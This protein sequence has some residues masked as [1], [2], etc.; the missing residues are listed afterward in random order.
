M[1]RLLCIAFCLI[2]VNFCLNA[3][4]LIRNGSF[5]QGLAHWT[6]KGNGSVDP[7]QGAF[8]K[9]SLKISLAKPVWQ[10]VFQTVDVEPST[11]YVLEYYVKCEKVL[12][13]KGAKFSGAGSWISMKKYFPH[14]GSA[15]PWKLDSADG[16]WRKVSYKF[17]TGKEDKKIAVQ[18]QLSNA[19]GTVWIDQVSLKKCVTSP[20][21]KY[22]IAFELN[23][24]KFLQTTPFTIAENLTGTLQ[25]HMR[26]SLKVR[27]SDPACM[28]FDVPSFIRVTGG[29]PYLSMESGT[30]EN[31]RR[32]LPTY[33]VEDLGMVKRSGKSFHRYRLI[34]DKY[35]KR[36]ISASWYSQFIFFKAEKGSAGKSGEFYCYISAG[37]ER[38]AEQKGFFKVVPPLK[39]AEKPTK[40]FALLFGKLP[41]LGAQN[42][43]G[44]EVNRA[45]W[46]SLAQKRYSWIRACD[47]PLKGFQPIV[48]VGGGFWSVID[49]VQGDLNALKKSLPRNITDKGTLRH[50]LAVWSKVDDKSGRVERLY[51]T[52]AKEVKRLYPEVKDVVWDFEPHPYGFDKGGRERF[53]RYMKL[54]EV[55]SI[56]QINSKYRTEWF[57][58]MVKLHAEYANNCMRIFKEAAPGVNFWFCS[59]NLYATGNHISSWC[60][61]DVRLSDDVAD[62][63]MHMPY[64]AGKRFFDDVR[65]NIENLKKPFFPLIDPSEA[66][67]SFYK[68]Y[69]PA[70]VKQNILAVA[71]RGGK[72][73]GFW[74]HDAFTAEYFQAIAEGFGMV[75]EAEEFYAKGKRAEKEFRVTPVNVMV[76]TVKAQNGKSVKL[77]FPD[78]PSVLRTVVH[79]YK[80]EVLFTLFNYHEKESMILELKGRGKTLYVNVPANGVRVVRLS[81]KQDPAVLKALKDFKAKSSSARLQ[82]MKKGSASLL[83]S[84][85]ESGSPCFRMQNGRI[86]AAVDV[87]KDG[88][89]ISLRSGSGSELLSGGF[90]GWLMFYDPQQQEV[91]SSI[92]SM[93]IRN[94]VPELTLKGV[95]GPYAGANPVPNPLLDMEI[96]RKY[97][98]KD[99]KLHMEFTFKNPTKKAMK[100]GFRLNNYPFPGK[101]FGAERVDCTLLSGGKRVK[102]S[103]GKNTFAYKGAVTP[104]TKKNVTLWDGGEIRSEAKKGSMED[105]LVIK[106]SSNFCGVMCWF[107]HLYNT[108]E[109]LSPYVT[110]PAGKKVSFSYEVVVSSR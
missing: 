95:V 99:N 64:Y 37:K 48:T 25:M 46:M 22:K 101:R 8:G 39:N 93:T 81:E 49:A 50:G 67:Y 4:D 53:A 19:S 74:P 80:N 90:L 45:F 43:P 7:G 59:D 14:H 105:T 29:V 3:S 70:K 83:W 87:M 11:E 97:S 13:K 94:G 65:F 62:G 89:I 96:Y 26:S 31:P 51:R 55:P 33:K 34:F 16:S 98:L 12:P 77:F 82:E 76:K 35:F 84:A 28:I 47:T 88:R 10:R 18:F 106:S 32:K 102:A 2:I 58:Y 23:P 42:I 5:E 68:Q 27:E 52:A 71:S 9:S 1:Q 54:K 60:G 79:A 100:I 44:Q 109:L 57:N 69:T 15:G 91:V 86:S 104:F 72:G 107:G 21:K 36:F 6:V 73:M 103:S 85:T 110:V 40:D 38:S 61:V 17:K 78:F 20:G 63:H 30:K 75:A 92:H 66:I 41:I 24:V 108:V 56:A